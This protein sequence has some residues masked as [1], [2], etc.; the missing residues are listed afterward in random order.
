VGISPLPATSI[1]PIITPIA[2]FDAKGFIAFDS[3]LL[4]LHT[5]TGNPAKS[6]TEVT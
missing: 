5:K 6:C 4:L 2:Y 3:S 1:R